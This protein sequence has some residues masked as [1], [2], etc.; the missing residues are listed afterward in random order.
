[1]RVP[2]E[3]HEDHRKAAFCL[4]PHALGPCTPVFDLES[5]ELEKELS[6]ELHCPLPVPTPHTS[7]CILA[8]SYLESQDKRSP[9]TL[10]FSGDTSFTLSHVPRALSGKQGPDKWTLAPRSQPFSI[11]THS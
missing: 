1:M 9:D 8:R 11:P 3:A 6:S 10:K 2:G 5:Q 4:C 7:V